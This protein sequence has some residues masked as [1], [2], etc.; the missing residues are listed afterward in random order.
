MGWIIDASRWNNGVGKKKFMIIKLI[1]RAIPFGIFLTLV[2]FLYVG[3]KQDPRQIPST[4]LNKPF[5][6][7]DLPTLQDPQIRF[8]KQE[9]MGHISLLTIWSSKCE[10]C[11]VEHPL[12]MDLAH[13]KKFILYGIN[14]K[15]DQKEAEQ[16]LKQYGNPYQQVGF[17]SDGKTSID[18]GVMSTPETFVIDQ[19]GITRFKLV[20]ELTPEIV[21]S[22]LL[23]L[24]AKLN[25][26]T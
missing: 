18:L 14:Y 3:L 16:W 21:Q 10:T 17:D 19:Q 2:L 1:C 12:L 9:L 4:L 22:K 5:P 15:D 6:A 8:R 25:L 20:G 23:P 24:I 26:A 13:N 11:N 7:F